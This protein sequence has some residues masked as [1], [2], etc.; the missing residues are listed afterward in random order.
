[1]GG[2]HELKFGFGYRDMT[3]HSITHYSGNQLAGDHQRRRRQRSRTS[4]ATASTNYG[5]KYLNVYLGD[6]FTK[7]RFT[8]NL[9]VRFD[10]QNGQEPAQRG[11]GQRG[12]P[13]RGARRSSFA[14]NDENLHR[15]ERPSRRAWA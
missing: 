5:G 14:G 4:G 12:V 11:A 6:I 8:L 2:N 3:T 13:E 15:V 9:G 10:R 1:M 7:D